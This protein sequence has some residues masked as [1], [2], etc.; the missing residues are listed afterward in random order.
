MRSLGEHGAHWLPW[1]I[2]LIVGHFAVPF[3]FMMSRHIKRQP[4][5]IGLGSVW[6]LVIHYVDI[7]WLIRPNWHNELNHFG[8]IDILTLLGIGGLFIGFATLL[9]RRNSLIPQKDPRL[10]ES[11]S[12]ENM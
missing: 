1:S 5:L 4:L 6:M 2:A 7:H 8:I 11:M 10:T 9:L 12:F 3:A